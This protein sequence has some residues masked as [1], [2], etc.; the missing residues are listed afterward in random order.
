MV[1]AVRQDAATAAAV[2]VPDWVRQRPAADPTARFLSPS[3]MDEAIRIAAPSPLAVAGG[4]GRFRRGDLIHRLLERLPD[5]PTASR[6]EAAVRMLSRERGL[7]DEQRAEMIA[8]AFGVLDDVRFAPVFGPGSRAEVAVTGSAPGLPPGV[9]IS[10][11]MDRLVVTPDRVLVVDYKTN[12]PAP[13]RIEDADPAYVRQM[14]AYVAVL[15]RLYPG[16]AVEAALVWT[17]G[18]DLMAVPPELMERALTPVR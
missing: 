17:D 5:L 4:L 12:R 10:G 18:P 6:H 7:S 1:M 9:T 3:Q 15:K 2:R 14:A 11:R 13:G 16:R 8:A